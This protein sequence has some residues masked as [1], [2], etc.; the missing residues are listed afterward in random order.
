METAYLLIYGSLP[1]KK[2]LEV[3]EKEVLHHGVVHADA[4]Q[5]CRSFR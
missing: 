2:Q 3:F 5:F 1:A 4:E